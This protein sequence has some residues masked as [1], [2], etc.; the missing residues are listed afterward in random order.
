[1]HKYHSIFEMSFSLFSRLIAYV[2]IH[3]IQNYHFIYLSDYLCSSICGQKNIRLDTGMVRKIGGICPLSQIICR[4]RI[5]RCT[6]LTI[7][8]RI[9]NHWLRSFGG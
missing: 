9:C 3:I 2:D 4:N 6:F 1:M 8:I 7:H 5:V